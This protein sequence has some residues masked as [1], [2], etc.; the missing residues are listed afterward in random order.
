MA[1]YFVI[2][3]ENPQ[4]RLIQQAVQLIQQGGVIA[5]PTDSSYALVCAMDFKDAQTRIRRLRGV[6]DDHPFTLLCRDLAEISTYAKVNNTQFRLLKA[7]TPGAYTF[8][9]EA[10]REVPRRLQ[11]PKRSTIGLRVPKHV[12]TQALLD[13]LN[14]PLIS[15]TLQMPDEAA[16]MSVGWEIRE[17]LEHQVDAVIDSDIV[18]VG[19]TTVLDLTQDPPELVR[20]GVAPWPL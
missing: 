19:A 8:L 17:T 11:H 10:S 18:H 16:P 13:A 20:A 9:L 4:S 6:D 12:V 15:M 5:C 1:Q 2:H 3:A 14:T 7:M